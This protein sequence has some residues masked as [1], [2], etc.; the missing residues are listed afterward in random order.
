MRTGDVPPVLHFFNLGV[1]AGQLAL[2]VALVLL[3]RFL[4]KTG[5]ALAPPLRP[6][7]GYALGGLA[8]LWLFDRLP[9]VW[10]T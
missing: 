4:G 7:M 1:E 3:Q 10:G 2:V 9:A 6:A 8:M 5:R